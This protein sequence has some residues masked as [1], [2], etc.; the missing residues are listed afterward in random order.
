MKKLT[1]N[2]EGTVKH[3]PNKQNPWRIHTFKKPKEGEIV[4]YIVA[5]PTGPQVI[6]WLVNDYEFYHLENGRKQYP[7]Q[8]AK[9]AL[10]TDLHKEKRWE[11]T[12]SYEPNF[13]IPK[14]TKGTRIPEKPQDFPKQKQRIE[15][16]KT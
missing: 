3:T 6:I 1:V 8:L 7:K 16:L 11:W 15:E 12:L 2:K 10:S 9:Y 14:S 4:G 13:A 5:S